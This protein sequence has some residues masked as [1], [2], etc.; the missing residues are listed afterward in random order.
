MQTVVFDRQRRIF[1]RLV[2]K[3]LQLRSLI[4]MCHIDQRQI[5]LLN[6]FVFSFERFKSNGY[7]ETMTIYL[8][9]VKDFFNCIFIVTSQFM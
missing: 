6:V 5:R 3:A 7:Y 9:A 8:N 2:G 1:V 4:N